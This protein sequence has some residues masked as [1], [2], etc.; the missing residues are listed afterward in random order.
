VLGGMGYLGI[1]LG[2]A[3]T[4]FAALAEGEGVD[5]AIHI[6]SRHRD[7]ART[8]PPAEALRETLQGVG[9]AVRWNAAALVAGCLVLC[10]SE[11]RPVRTLG[12]LLAA[13]MVVSYAMS[14]LMLPA[15]LVHRVSAID[16]GPK[17]P[18]QPEAANRRG[19]VSESLRA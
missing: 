4:M 13:G 10:L 11:I 9:T 7:L 1:T 3:T 15:L 16:R 5:F 17:V 8:R 2:V 12:A 6:V 14:F 18:A 19:D